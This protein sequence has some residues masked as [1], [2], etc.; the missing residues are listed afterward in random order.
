MGIVQRRDDIGQDDEGVITYNVY[1]DIVDP[2]EEL[3]SGMTVD[4]DIVTNELADVL[5]VPNTAVKPYQGGKSVRIL[6]RETDELENIPVTI[7]IKGEIYTQ[8]LDG[9]QEGD[10][11]VVSLTNDKVERSGAF[12]F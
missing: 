9:I 8:I 10:E 7:G 12:G 11:I 6:N 4:V 5:A 1:I 3:K 2:D